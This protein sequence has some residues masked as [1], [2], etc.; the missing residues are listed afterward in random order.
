MYLDKRYSIGLVLILVFAVVLFPALGQAQSSL[1]ELW[2]DETAEGA[3]DS[4]VVNHGIAGPPNG[5]LMDNPDVSDGVT[6][7]PTWSDSI[8]FDVADNHSLYFDNGNHYVHLGAETGIETQNYTIEMWVKPDTLDANYMILLQAFNPDGVGIHYRLQKL[9]S[10]DDWAFDCMIADANGT[11]VRMRSDFGAITLGEWQHLAVTYDTTAGG[12]MY[13]DGDTVDTVDPVAEPQTLTRYWRVGNPSGLAPKGNIDEVRISDFARVVGDST[14]AD[15]SLAI[16]N[17][18][19]TFAHEAP[20]LVSPADGLGGTAL[21]QEVTWNTVAEADSYRVQLSTREDFWT[22]VVDT[23]IGNVSAFTAEELVTNTTYHWRVASVTD[24][25]VSNWSESRSFSTMKSVPVVLGEFRFDSGKDSTAINSGAFLRPEALLRNGTTIG[26]GID[27]T[28]GPVWSEDTPMDYEGNYSLYYDGGAQY[29]HTGADAGKYVDN[30]T[31]ESWIK[32]VPIADH[33]QSR[34]YLMKGLTPSTTILHFYVDV[35]DDYDL[36]VMLKDLASGSWTVSQTTTGAITPDVWQHVAM[37]YDTTDGVKLYIDGTEVAAGDTVAPFQITRYWRPGDAFGVSF[38]GN[39][40]DFRITDMARVPGDGSG[41]AGMLAWNNALVNI[42]PEQPTLAVP[43]DSATGVP[44]APT[45]SSNTV[46]DVESYR[47]QVGTKPDFY[48]TLADTGGFAFPSFSPGSLAENT[49]YYWRVGGVNQYGV[50]NWSKKFVFTTGITEPLNIVELW[51]DDGADSIVTD[52]GAASFPTGELRDGTQVTDG[53]N[54]GPTWSEDTPFSYEGNYSLHFGGGSHAVQ[55][56]HEPEVESM[57]IEAWIKPEHSET[58]TYQYLTQ[59]FDAITNRLHFRLQKLGDGWEMDALIWDLDKGGW[60]RMRT[61]DGA[62]T[63]GEW[64]H[65]ALTHDPVTGSALYINGEQVGSMP[66]IPTIQ[67]SR[68]YRVG[69]PIANSFNGNID[70]WRVSNFAR[71]PGDGSGTGHSLA[72]NNSLHAIAAEPAVQETPADSTAD[73]QLPVTVSWSSSTDANAYRVQ[74]FN[75]ADFMAP[76]HVKFDQT[77]ITDTFVQVPADSLMYGADYFWRVGAIKEAGTSN[78][79]DVWNFS[80][81]G[82]PEVSPTLV[83]PEDSA[84]VS[85]DTVKFVWDAVE[86]ATMYQLVMAKDAEF[87]EIV[88]NDSGVTETETVARD[89]EADQEY[90]WKVR[91]A[92]EAGWGPYSDTRMFVGNTVGIDRD[93]G[94]PKVFALYQNY[95]NPFN[96]VTTIRYDLPKQTDVKIVIYDI[97]GKQVDVLVNKEQAAGRYSIQYDGSRLSSGMYFYRIQAPD[98][99]KVEKMILLK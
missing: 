47:F 13:I 22:A 48:I 60:A 37:T 20:T 24:Y 64:Q 14:G 65:I 87:T 83:T 79:S 11:F 94:I 40:D 98:F 6:F 77:A 19:S 8:P 96:P 17:P 23:F 92:N 53:A 9:V 97:L 26:D 91:A 89:L 59:W 85:E 44:E 1:V 70:E 31:I 81:L 29:I 42:A 33:D 55:L 73:L 3:V 76:M 35:G 28:L 41:D 99:T 90:Y 95:P 69:N 75:A 15:S 18:L 52:H 62:I 27:T 38:I 43:A 57:T 45:L 78:W 54:A 34:L 80:T 16:K 7:G 49:M 88:L 68:W 2:F 46:A 66:P 63:I 5:R 39:I 50:T 86:G 82:P 10:G 74:V 72:W 4:M 67:F 51:F 25:G 36:K 61:S 93:N 21:S 12:I 30:F 56:G 84:S 58:Q 32:P 71:I